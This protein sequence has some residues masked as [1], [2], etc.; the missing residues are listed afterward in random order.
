MKYK[1]GDKVEVDFADVAQEAKVK[2][3]A[4]NTE[5]IVIIEK[6]EIINGNNYY[7]L[8][9]LPAFLWHEIAL[10]EYEEEV[11]E[12]IENRFEILDL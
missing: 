4:L 7:R 5:R 1:I 8:K 10:L 3:N 6:I 9:D 11:Y 12:P 2:V